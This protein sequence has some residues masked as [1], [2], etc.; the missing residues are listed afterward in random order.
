MTS[1][2]TLITDAKCRQLHRVIKSGGEKYLCFTRVTSAWIVC[3][4]DG[5]SL[6][7]VD[8][9]EEETDALRDL[10]G[11]NTMEAFLTRFRLLFSVIQ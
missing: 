11:I 8:L 7:K 9:D 2:I 6:W 3:V 10:A 4:T 1:F 5:V